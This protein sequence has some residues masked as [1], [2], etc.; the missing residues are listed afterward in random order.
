VWRRTRAAWRAIEIEVSR[1]DHEPAALL[2][3]GGPLLALAGDLIVSLEFEAG[4]ANPA[5]ATL[6]L[7]WMEATQ[8]AA[9]GAGPVE[10]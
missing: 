8:V 9:W 2:H 4:V 10:D 7:V 1:N 3:G 5:L 6:A